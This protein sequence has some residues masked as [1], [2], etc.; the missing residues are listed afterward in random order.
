MQEEA[1][2]TQWLDI[3]AA[4]AQKALVMSQDFP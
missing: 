3:V 2:M 1:S 4:M